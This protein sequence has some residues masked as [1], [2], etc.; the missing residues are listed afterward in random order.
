MKN[1][2]LLPLP[3]FKTN[4]RRAV[5][6]RRKF[7]FGFGSANILVRDFRDTNI[8]PDRGELFENFVMAEIYKRYRITSS[9]IHYIFIVNTEVK[10]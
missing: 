6:A 1:Y 4:L 9:T 10:R 5:S 8:R 2:I 7:Y 3:A